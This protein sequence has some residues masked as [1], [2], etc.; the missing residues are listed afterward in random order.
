LVESTEENRVGGEEETSIAGNTETTSP[1]VPGIRR[2]L[3]LAGGTGGHIFPALSVAQVLRSR[4]RQREEADRGGCRYDI[5]FAGTN[6]GLEGRLIPGAGFP[7]QTISGAGLKGIGGW[8]K[9]RNFFWML[10]K[11]SWESAVLLRQLRPHAVLGMGGYISGP[12]MLEAALMGI[13]TLL[14]EPNA[15]PGFTNRVLGPVVQLAAVGFEEA[16]HFYGSKAR[17]TGHPVREAFFG[18]P[19]RKSQPPFTLLIFGG[20]QGSRAINR[21]MAQTL[22]LFTKGGG[23]RWNFIHQTGERDYNEIQDAYQENGLRAD[24][25]AF[26]DD[27]PAAFA[28]A[29]VIISRSGANTVA[30]LAAA[31][32]ASLLIPFPGATDQHQLENARAL[33]RAGAARLLQE[34]DVNP[35][36]LLGMIEEMLRSP[37]LTQEMGSKA[38]ALAKPDAAER[39]ADLMKELAERD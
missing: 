36:R 16:A 9:V 2:L 17:L 3:M 24:V 39:I 35:E 20:S 10:P 13:P 5:R 8:R 19:A 38:R 23:E 32:K 25:R 26:I 27:M 7:L 29:D 15:V 30:E 33:E 21:S 18:I 1:G 12:A 14:I 37:E 22:P 11:S 6:R 28:R 31:G 4:N 34:A